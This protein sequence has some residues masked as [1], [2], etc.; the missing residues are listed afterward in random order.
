[1]T[2]LATLPAFIGKLREFE[3]RILSEASVVDKRSID[4]YK[5]GQ[6]EPVL[7]TAF[8][9]AEAMRVS[10]GTANASEKPLSGACSQPNGSSPRQSVSVTVEVD[11][12][13]HRIIIAERS[14]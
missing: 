12:V 3:T 10:L 8:K 4:R 14:A 1:M 11:G 13:Q 7:S 2:A 6:V 5:S 9:L